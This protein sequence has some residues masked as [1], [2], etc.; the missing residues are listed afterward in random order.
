MHGNT[1]L[2]LIWTVIPVVILAVIGGFVFF[3]LPEDLGRPVGEREPTAWTSRSKA[4]SSTGSSTTR[5][6]RARSATCTSRSGKVVYL[7]IVSPDVDH[8]WW[9]PQLGGKTD[10]IPGKT[11]HTWFKA[12]AA[13]T[14][15]GQCAEFCGRLPRGDARARD[16]DVR[17]RVPELA[18]IGRDADLGRAGVPGRLRDV[19]RDA[20]QGGYGPALAA[21][22]IITQPARP[23]RDRPQR[24]RARCRRSATLDEPRRSTRSLAYLKKNI[25]KGAAASGG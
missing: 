6:A 25:Y 4:T 2:E 10:A 14:Y 5:T 16:R 18:R 11:N 13:G 8:S 7:T 17:R 12:D 15:A 1:R 19:P 20:G 24:P 22:S 3:E 21:N 9:I 23:R